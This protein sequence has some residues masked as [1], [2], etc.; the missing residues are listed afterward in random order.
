MVDT[1]DIRWGDQLAVVEVHCNWPSS[2]DP[3]YVHA[4]LDNQARWNHYAISGVP[5]VSLDGYKLPSWSSAATMVGSLIGSYAPLDLTI[6]P[7]D[8][9]HIRVEVEEPLPGSNNRLFV[10]IVE[11]SLYFPSAPNGEIWAS[12]VLRKLL[13]SSNGQL[14]DLS[15]V[16]S[17]NF[18]FPLELH[19]AWDTDHLKIIA[20]VQNMAGPVSAY[21]IH[22]AKVEGWR[23]DGYHHSFTTSRAK[24]FS[25]PGETAEFRASI[26]NIGS[27]DDTYSVWVESEVP[28]GWMVRAEYGATPFD[29]T[30]IFLGSL[31]NAQF[32]VFIVPSTSRGQG[33]VR[34][35]LQSVG[36]TTGAVDTLMFTVMNGGD[37][38]YIA[39]EAATI[40][41]PTFHALFA[42][43]GV[44]FHEWHISADGALPDFSDAP[45]SA[46]VW[47]E[48]FNLSTSLSVQ[49]RSSIRD[50]LE[51]G[52]KMLITSASW[53]RTI[54]GVFDFYYS[55]LGA[56]TDGV[57]SSPTSVMG[58][59]GGT[60]FTGFSADLGGLLA[61]GMTVTAP[62]RAILRLS[63]GKTCGLTRITDGGGKLVYVSFR[64]EDIATSAGLNDFWGRV[65]DFWG[66]F[67]VPEREM[68]SE[69]ALVRTFPNPFNTALSIDI[70]L[71]KP[72]N[73]TVEAFDISGR[74]V[75]S[76]YSGT[77]S[78][79]TTRVQ[80]DAGNLPSG[81]FLIR[82]SGRD[83]SEQVK[84]I[85]IK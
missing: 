54:G 1:L 79:N 31:E 14:V 9:I 2:S 18:T 49:D 37:L 24:D 36:D 70:E 8:N 29:S 5:S 60:E 47:H 45:Y 69:K 41:I 73:I 12:N 44:D 43:N 63:S 46:I 75:E 80:W 59:Y 57:E 21:N 58:T 28:A 84:T 23:L 27:L 53:G 40:D 39:G 22:N 7:G 34:L 71:A 16:G 32:D 33:R 50:Y 77:V 64:L 82:V 51:G 66:G 25:A 48:G 17:Q 26:S 13:P 4:P 65:E 67:D 19:S 74:L 55:V 85:L 20:W 81:I 62:S 52:G 61:E 30:A 42:D 83:F 38:L 72:D 56:I 3:Y 76:I 11:D 10:A 78:A 35:L 6:I 68:P 15:G